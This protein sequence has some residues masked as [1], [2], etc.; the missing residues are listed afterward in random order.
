MSLFYSLDYRSWQDHRRAIL[1]RF[2]AQFKD[3]YERGQIE[4]GDNL[5]ERPSFAVLEDLINE[6]VD[7][8][9][10]AYTLFD[11]LGAIDKA[12][13]EAIA[14]EIAPEDAIWRIRRIL[15]GKVKKL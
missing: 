10:Y 5:W 14:G 9:A 1:R 4:H 6:V 15:R 11:Q 7:Q 8:A 13:D 3:K 2:E 12:C